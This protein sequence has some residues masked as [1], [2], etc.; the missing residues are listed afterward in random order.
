MWDREQ[1]FAIFKTE[2][3]RLG[4]SKKAS[5][6]YRTFDEV[7]QIVNLQKS[8]WSS[9]DH[10]LNIA[11]YLRALGDDLKPKISLGQICGRPRELFDPPISTAVE[12]ALR[13]NDPRK[14][15]LQTEELLTTFF[16]E[17]FA[18][19]IGK[20]QSQQAIR[21]GIVA[22]GLQRCRVYDSAKKLMEI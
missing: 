21:E 5:T 14:S 9:D 2:L 6:W 13:V 20:Y 3:K 7:I 10:Y 8:S 16:R 15:S 17:P 22:G 4:F 19:V 18:Q 12:D 1:L 11:F